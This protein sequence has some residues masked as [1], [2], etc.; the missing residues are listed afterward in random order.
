MENTPM[1]RA[2]VLILKTRPDFASGLRIDLKKTCWV[3]GRKKS[4]Y[5]CL[6]LDFGNRNQTG[7]I[8]IPAKSKGFHSSERVLFLICTSNTSEINEYDLITSS[9]TFWFFFFK[10][11]L[12]KHRKCFNSMLSYIVR[13]LLGRSVL[14]ADFLRVPL[15]FL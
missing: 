11:M 7:N 12:I 14:Q 10:F 3:K 15:R 9:D 5:L 1:M 2:S 13:I 4:C 6:C 8:L